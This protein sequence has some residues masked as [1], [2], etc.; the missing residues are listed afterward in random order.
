MSQQINLFNPL[1]RKKGFSFTSALA[2]LYGAGIAVAVMALTVTYVERDLN[3]TRAL[4]Q[5]VDAQF[6]AATAQRDKLA[7]EVSLQKPS[8][9]LEKEVADLDA[10]LRSRQEVVETLKSGAIG[11]TQGFSDYMLAFSRQ[12]VSGLWLTGFDVAL[13]GNELAIQG[14][15]LNADLV[16]KYLNRL[17]QEKALSGRQFGAMRITRQQMPAVTASAAEPAKKGETAAAKEAAAA[18]AAYLEFSVS[19]IELPEASRP[20]AARAEALPAPLLGTISPG[21]LVDTAR[22]IA[23]GAP[24]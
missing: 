21:A 12:S 15:A 1:F 18:G 5:G 16:P 17:T 6:K 14:R 24:K 9:Q 7:A 8:P 20:A 22:T 4:A 11:N 13:A 2:M 3:A 10:L 19:T 23:A